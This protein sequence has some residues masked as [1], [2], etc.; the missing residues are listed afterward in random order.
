MDGSL[1]A[2]SEL[3]ATGANVVARAVARGVY[4]AQAL[5]F[6]GTLAAWRDRFAP[7]VKG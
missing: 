1:V 5:P 7:A 6:P 3:G 4:E 2:L